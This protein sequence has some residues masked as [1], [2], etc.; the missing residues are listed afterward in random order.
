MGRIEAAAFYRAF[1]TF[2]AFS[3]SLSLSSLPACG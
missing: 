1:C 3:F 2:F